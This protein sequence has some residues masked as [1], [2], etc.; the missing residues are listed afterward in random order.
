MV[1]EGNGSMFEMTFSDGKRRGMAFD[2]H[3]AHGVF[4]TRGGSMI[5]KRD[6]PKVK[7]TLAVDD[8]E[9]TPSG[10]RDGA[11]TQDRL[12]QLRSIVKR[13]ALET[14]MDDAEYQRLLDKVT[15]H[16]ADGAGTDKGKGARDKVRP[17][18]DDDDDDLADFRKH[19]AAKGLSAAE[20]E[21]ACEHARRDYDRDNEAEDVIPH[22]ALGGRLHGRTGSGTTRPDSDAELERQY[23]GIGNV[24]DDVYGTQPEPPRYSGGGSRRVYA[25]DTAVVAT[26]EELALEYPG[27]ENVRV[28]Y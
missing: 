6:W 15:E 14:G 18:R 7:R 19:L 11:G 20:I 4:M 21:E 12:A 1:M 26:D 9:L 8:N 13:L 10:E 28:G 22:N 25:G 24:L 17:A 27:I 16:Y 5:T 3:D 2:G 23:P